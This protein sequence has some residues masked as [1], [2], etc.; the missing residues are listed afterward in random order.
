M[1]TLDEFL[2][3][4]DSQFTYLQTEIRITPLESYVRF[5]DYINQVHGTK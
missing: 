1:V 3:F 2:Y 5:R 4:C